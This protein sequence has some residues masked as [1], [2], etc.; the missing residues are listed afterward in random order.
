MADDAL[1][2]FRRNFEIFANGQAAEIEAVRVVL[3]ALLVSTFSMAP[4]GPAQFSTLRAMTLKRLEAETT[5]PG[6]DQDATR[7][8]EFV[9]MRAT[10]I[11]DEMAPAFQR[12]P[13]P[14]PESQ[15]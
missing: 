15:N 6:N 8:A 5:D 7:K 10:Q 12:D 3:Q 4:D 9:L 11:F 14:P 13:S 2:E 1:E